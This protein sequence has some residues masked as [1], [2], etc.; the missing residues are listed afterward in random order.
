MIT[1][2]IIE[3]PA[4]PEQPKFPLLA[5]STAGPLAVMFSER[6]KGTVISA[7]ECWDVGDFYEHWVPCPDPQFWRILPP[8]TKVTLE[9]K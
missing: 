8:G 4:T 2:T 9:V 6:N 5:Q 1:S 7:G 3:P